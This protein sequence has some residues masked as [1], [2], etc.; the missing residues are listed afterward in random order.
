MRVL[1]FMSENNEPVKV[2]YIGGPDERRIFIAKIEK[3]IDIIFR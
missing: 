2:G 3:Y 1:F